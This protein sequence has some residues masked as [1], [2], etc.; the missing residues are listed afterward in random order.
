MT[1]TS[2]SP[3]VAT[4]P[5]GPL[6]RSLRG[7]LFGHSVAA[8]SG[9]IDDGDPLTGDDFHLALHLCY[10]LGY[11][12]LTGVD[13]AM[14][15]HPAVLELRRDLEA[16]FEQALRAES[17]ARAMPDK[18]GM[19]VD[20]LLRQSWGPSLST[21][22][23]EQGT[24][25]Q[26]LEFLIHR[27][28]YQLKEADAHSWAIPRMPPGRRKSALVEIQA[29]EYGNGRPGATHAELF[30]DV[31]RS[32]G[33]DARYG[34]YVDRLPG[35][36]LATDNLISMFGLRRELTAA[37]LGHLAVFEMTSVEPMSRYSRAAGRLGFGPAVRRFYDVHVE[38][39]AHHGDLARTSLLGGD[40]RAEGFDPA[41][42]VFGAEALL[43]VE[44]RF[45]RLLLDAWNDDRTAL[46]PL[47]HRSS[48]S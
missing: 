25:V 47:P 45:T 5:R 2:F 17:P 23:D 35:A 22:M 15:W 7:I 19:A 18:A 41:E 20:E 39:D 43:R 11:R 32:A 4:A 30:A 13:P 3:R 26:F 10:E 38:A 33:L 46:L 9:A 48:Q 16:K 8:P 6:T 27:S 12:G 21:F 44:E 24:R 42:V 29:D 28:A 40:L 1:A 14:E 31:M 36:T 37:L 34:A